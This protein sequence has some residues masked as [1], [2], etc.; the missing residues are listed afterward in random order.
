MV[1]IESNALVMAELLTFESIQEKKNKGKG[2][3]IDP[4]GLL[5]VPPQRLSTSSCRQILSHLRGGT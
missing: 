3:D 4:P 2:T 5:G 1:A